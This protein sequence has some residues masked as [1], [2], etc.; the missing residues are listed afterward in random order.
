MLKRAKTTI[1]I[2]LVLVFSFLWINPLLEGGTVLEEDEFKLIAGETKVIPTRSPTKVVIAHPE[3]ADI[4][5]VTN[6]EIRITAK[7]S[8]ATTL[9]FWDLFGE[10]NLKIR[11][12]AEDMGEIKRR[13][14]NILKSLDYPNVFSRALDEEGKVILLGEVKTPAERERITV[15]LT[16]LKDK[17]VDL[18]EIK[19]EETIIE[20]DAQ[21][22]ELNKDATNTLGFSWPGTTTITEKGSPGL[23]AAGTQWSR[24][25]RVLNVNRA[26][27]TLQLDALVQEGKARVLSRPRLACQSGKE[28]ELLVGGEKPIMTTDVVSGGGSDTNVEYKEYGIKLIIRPTVTKD[29][30]IKL[31]LNLEISDV[32]DAEILG[33]ASSPSARAYPL[34]KRNASTELFVDDGQTLSIGGLIRE[35]SEEDIR[36]TPWL[37]DIPILGF[38]FKKKTS[39]V[40]GGEGERGDR[41]LFITITPTIISEAEAQKQAKEAGEVEEE[42]R[43]DV[44]VTVA[45]NSP[46]ASG[47]IRKDINNP[48]SEYAHLI[49]RRVL[50][51]L[52]YPATAKKSS[53]QGT[54]KLTLHLSYRGELLDVI[55]RKSSGYQILDENAIFAAQSVSLYP[56][57]PTTIQQAEL[58]IDVPIV[59]RLD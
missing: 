18:I 4:V 30:R 49:Q 55:V 57:F 36:K 45:S 47:I 39:T 25:F 3:I 1:L 2:S 20:I 44:A 59:Y 50:E 26:A 38:F 37:G 52:I 6:E 16:T 40:G 27:F 11:V 54:V 21:L 22:L 17:V 32:G 43:P 53:F 58:Q 24:L 23:D 51:N 7:S 29:K 41:E 42:I 46:G 8:G 28:A 35:K 48:V 33:S 15:A 5:D 13:V 31:V 14:D 9:D 12:V 19:E 10:H 56:P 34:T